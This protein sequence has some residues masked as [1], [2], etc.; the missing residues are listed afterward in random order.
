MTTWIF[1][2]VILI[3]C[4]VLVY[5]QIS[6]T[7]HSILIGLAIGAALVGIEAAL[8]AISL[9]AS[10]T[11][12]VGAAAGIFVSKLSDYAMVQ[13]GNETWFQIWDRY[14][15]LRHFAFGAMGAVL[16]MRKV[17]EL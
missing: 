6:H 2:A 9:F 16:L 10:V 15:I 11:A 8:E 5:T 3:G 1:R 4:P 12:I 13:I 14:A 7:H 17:P